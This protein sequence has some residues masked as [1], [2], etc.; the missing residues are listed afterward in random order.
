MVQEIQLTDNVW[1]GMLLITKFSTSLQNLQLVG[2]VLSYARQTPSTL[3]PRLSCVNHDTISTIQDTLNTM[4]SLFTT[5]DK[6]SPFHTVYRSLLM[7]QVARDVRIRM[8]NHTG[9]QRKVAFHTV[10]TF[11]HTTYAIRETINDLPSLIKFQAMVELGDRL[12]T[13]TSTC[14]DVNTVEHGLL[15]FFIDETYLSFLESIQWNQLIFFRDI[16]FRLSSDLVQLGTE[17]TSKA[18]EMI[19]TM[20]ITSTVSPSEKL[21]Q[22]IS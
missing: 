19:R 20:Q 2:Q 11:L 21:I 14:S 22:L 16:M 15:F 4:W 5:L 3:S 12:L 13:L 1:S 9:I 8:R 17:F 7:L 6:Y 18:N 10:V